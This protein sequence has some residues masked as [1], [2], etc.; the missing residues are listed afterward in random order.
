[1]VLHMG[2]ILATN[3]IL[4]VMMNLISSTQLL[5]L[6]IKMVSSAKIFRKLVSY[7]QPSHK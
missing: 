7:E 6:M 4:T 1:M 5:I 2:R 3:D